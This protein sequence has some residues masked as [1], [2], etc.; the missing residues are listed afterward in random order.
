MQRLLRH[1]VLFSYKDTVQDAQKAEVVRRFS[2]LPSRIG[3]IHHFECGR[4][5]SPEGLSQG[6]ED[7]FL[8]TFL[9]EADRDVYLPHPAHRA[10]VDF[11]S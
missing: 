9:C 11:L 10:F 1:I 5:N 4:N 3:A 2:E 8:L 7:C 6:F